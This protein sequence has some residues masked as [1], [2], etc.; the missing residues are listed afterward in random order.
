MEHKICIIFICT[1][2]FAKYGSLYS[3]Y[4]RNMRLLTADTGHSW[5]AWGGHTAL[6]P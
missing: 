3:K 1:S 4:V 2:I 5:A 6:Y